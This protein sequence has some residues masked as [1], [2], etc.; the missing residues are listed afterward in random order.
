MENTTLFSERL[1][2]LQNSF[3]KQAEKLFNDDP[4]RK[5]LIDM[6]AQSQKLFVALATVTKGYEIAKTPKIEKLF[7]KTLETVIVFLLKD[8]L[9]NKLDNELQNK[10]VNEKLDIRKTGEL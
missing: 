9:E 7:E 1:D 8:N 10:G 5:Y 3:C 6:R 4:K 2:Y